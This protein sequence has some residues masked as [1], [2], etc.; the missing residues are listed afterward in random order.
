MPRR[1]GSCMGHTGRKV[2]VRFLIL[3][4]QLPMILGLPAS[5]ALKLRVDLTGIQPAIE[6]LSAQGEWQ[7]VTNRTAIYSGRQP[8]TT[9]SALLEMEVPVEPPSLEAALAKLKGR[10]SPEIEPSKSPWA[11]APVFVP[12]KNGKWRMALDYRQLNKLTVPD[13]YPLP[14]TWDIVQFA[15]SRESQAPTAFLAPS[16]LYEWTVMPFGIDD[17]IVA[18]NEWIKFLQGLRDVLE[19]LGFEVSEA[20]ISADPKKVKALSLPP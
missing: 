10:I 17:T 7:T 20:G 3:P 2:Q 12:K 6:A 19:A 9:R 13:A 14:H 8:P 5:M 4:G 11:S 1:R 16:G 15:L 18:N